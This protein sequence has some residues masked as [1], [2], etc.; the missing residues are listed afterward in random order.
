[1]IPRANPRAMPGARR[2][3][4]VQPMPLPRLLDIEHLR[5]TQASDRC[6]AWSQRQKS[7]GAEEKRQRKLD[8]ARRRDAS[9][10]RLEMLERKER[11]QPR[12]RFPVA[13]EAESIEQGLIKDF[14]RCLLGQS[15]FETCCL[16]RQTHVSEAP[17]DLPNAIRTLSCQLF[18]A[19]LPA[20]SVPERDLALVWGDLRLVDL[21]NDK[22]NGL[23]LRGPRVR[24]VIRPDNVEHD[25]VIRGIEVMTV[26]VPAARRMM[27]LDASALER[28]AVEHDH[29]VA[30]I[31]SESVRPVPAV[32]DLDFASF[33]RS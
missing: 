9:K 29:R 6:V 16:R 26:V 1:M 23:S 10:D 13:G 5:R 7:A 24:A 32:D 20:D 31:G 12:H 14:A 22:R 8:S 19:D 25:I 11:C 15:R 18:C 27:E 30:E 2:H 33:H 4:F 21:E 17:K 3:R 28:A